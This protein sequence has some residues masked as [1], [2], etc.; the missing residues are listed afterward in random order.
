M[1]RRKGKKKCKGE[2]IEGRK[3]TRREEEGWGVEEEEWKRRRGR[4][5]E[6]EEE[7]KRG[8]RGEEERSR[9]IERP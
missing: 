9:D 6:E 4:R 1:R 7:R 2:G 8:R 5:G 3:V